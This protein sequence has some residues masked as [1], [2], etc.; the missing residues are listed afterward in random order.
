MQIYRLARGSGGSR[1]GR[2]ASRA[3]FRNR[4]YAEA[5]NCW[6]NFQVGGSRSAGGDEPT[7]GRVVAGPEA[8]EGAPSRPEPSKGA[9]SGREQS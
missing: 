2:G 7:P 8:P 1:E 3:P 9:R 5:S 4:L 6:V